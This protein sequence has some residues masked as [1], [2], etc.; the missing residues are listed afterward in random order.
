MSASKYKEWFTE[1]PGKM[2]DTYS[3]A[4]SSNADT[5]SYGMHELSKQ[6]VEDLR[7][8]VIGESNSSGGNMANE[9]ALYRGK[10]LEAPNVMM[11]LRYLCK[12]TE[13]D[14]ITSTY[15]VMEPDVYDAL[16]MASSV[17]HKLYFHK[18]VHIPVPGVKDQ[19]VTMQ[20]EVINELKSQMLGN[21]E[22]K[23]NYISQVQHQMVCTG[24]DFALVS[25]LSKNGQLTVYPI[26][27]DNEWIADYLKEVAEFWRRVE[28]N[29]PY[30]EPIDNDYVADLNSLDE[31]DTLIHLLEK[32]QEFDVQKKQFDDDKKSI[33]EGIKQV[34][35]RFDVSKAFVGPFKISLTTVE[36]K[37]QPERV[38]PATPGSTYEKLTVSLNKE[39]V[40]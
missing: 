27:R 36:R 10:V 21:G 13:E 25:V 14:N 9:D 2:T 6:T 7:K 4:G 19:Y 37:P 29:D 16:Q 15:P 39:N 26:E 20:G 1:H 17:D 18:P 34:L 5:I 8:F 31:S 35:K 23:R 11:T 12:F 3:Q 32:R 28:E 38:V 33:D 24:G 40:Q 22:L 30:P